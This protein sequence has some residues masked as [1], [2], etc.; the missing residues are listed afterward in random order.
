[1]KRLTKYFPLFILLLTTLP[2]MA[3]D[4]AASKLIYELNIREE[5][6]PPV[7]HHTQK[8]FQE[9]KTLHADIIII[10]MNTYGGMLD[11]ADSIRTKILDSKIPVYVFID[12]NAASAGALISIA[13][14]SIYMAPGS[15]MGAATVVDQKGEVL[16]DK[17]QSYMRSIMRATAEVNGRNPD[18]AQAMVDPSIYIKGVSDTGKVL[19]FTPSEAIKNGFCEAEVNSVNELLQHAGI[20]HYNIKQQQLTATDKI[21]GFLINPVISGILIMII[22]GGIYFEL[23]TPGIGFPLAAAVTAALLY[24]APLYLEGMA[25]HWEILLFIVGLI[26]L[27]LEIFAIPGFGVTGFA[28]ILLITTGLTLSLVKHIGP[29]TFDYDLSGLIKALFLVVI[30]MSIGILISIFLAK[31]L[32]ESPSFRFALNNRQ[33]ASEGYTIAAKEYRSMIGKTGVAQ[34]QLRPAGKVIIEG[35]QYDAVSQISYINKGEQVK[36]ISYNNGQLT[37][38]KVR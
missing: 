22:I 24:F 29:G 16:P 17:Y 10:H 34:T 15:S 21:T 4:T 3:Q 7:W 36:V 30:S 12:K 13:C 31:R 32:L 8:A 26:L 19:T 25:S 5:I 23:Q 37:V 27:A 14:D 33:L 9:A 20:K 18:I 11:A 2:L 1:M 28:G 38:R 35:E 6:A